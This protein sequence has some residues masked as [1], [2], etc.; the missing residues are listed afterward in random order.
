[1]RRTANTSVSPTIGMVVA[2]TGKI[3]FGPACAWAGVVAAA[4]ASARAPVARIVRRSRWSM[5]VLPLAL[6]AYCR[7]RKRPAPGAGLIAWSIVVS[8][9]D[10]RRQLAAVGG[11]LGHH[12]LVQPDVHAR[13][14]VGVAGV[15]ELLG[16][17]LARRKAGVDVE[18]LHQVDDGVLPVQLL[19]LGRDR[20]VEDGSDVDGLRRRSRRSRGRPARS[21]A[22]GRRCCTGLAEDR[23][24]DGSENT[25]R[26][27]PINLK[28]AWS[29]LGDFVALSCTA[30]SMTVS[31]R[32]LNPEGTGLP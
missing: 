20:L 26:S 15:A 25:H 10:L 7:S 19:P 12:L 9:L 31:P 18:R 29:C 13:R 16:E 1:M 32:D 24:H 22:A 21:C 6:V 23:T 11:E 28:M 4:P 30:D 27:L 3:D 17:V 5:G 2:A 14:V 8:V